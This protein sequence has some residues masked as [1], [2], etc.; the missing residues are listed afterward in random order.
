MDHLH[1]ARHG[2]PV[3]LTLRLCVKIAERK[4]LPHAKTQRR[5]DT[6]SQTKAVARTIMEE[7][8][9]S[10]GIKPSPERGISPTVRE[11]S[12]SRVFGALPYGRASAP[13]RRHRITPRPEVKSLFENRFHMFRAKLTMR[14]GICIFSQAKR[15]EIPCAL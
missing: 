4:E 14:L 13:N 6:Q 10:V 1:H 8:G 2:I 3:C 12:S 11:G 5:Q 9:N 15:A 7:W